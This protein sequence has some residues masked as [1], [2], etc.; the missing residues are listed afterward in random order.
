ML[1]EYQEAS[2]DILADVLRPSLRDDDFN[3][4]KKV[5]I[6]EIQMYADR[7]VQYRLDYMEKQGLGIRD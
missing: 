7:Y 4:E 5:I 2:V 1:P 3:M 6:E